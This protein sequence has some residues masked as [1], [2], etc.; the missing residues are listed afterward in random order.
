MALCS[1]SSKLTT[2]GYT[3]I[4]NNFFNEFLPQATGDDVKVYL[5]G[6]TLCNTLSSDENSLDTICKVLSLTEEQVLK[7][8]D[9]WQMVGLVQVVSKNPY[10]VRY[11]P[12]RA[13]SGSVKIRNKEKYADFNEQIQTVI[14]G[15]MITPTEFNEYYSLIE[16]YHFEP[17]AVVL[18]ASYCTK[19]KNTSIG[20]PYIMAVA[21]DFEKQ[22]LKT[23]SAIENKLIEKE[24]STAEIKQ[25]LSALGL[26]READ[27]EERNLYLK[28]TNNFGFIH[29]VIVEV[30][31]TLKK[32]G[33]FIK[34]D[35][36][37]SKYYEQKLFT[38]EE[39]LS[40]SENRDSMFELAKTV[41]KT[42]GLYYQN[43][44][45]IVDTYIA[46]W[47]NKGYDN[48]TL[49]FIGHYCFKQS[50]RTLEGMNTIIQKFF[51]LGLISLA[52]IE[53]YISGI[54]KT[55]E[56]IKEVVDKTGLIRQ[57]S[58]LDREFYKTWTNSWGFTHEQILLAAE[59]AKDKSNP[60]T[61]LNKV[62]AN[63]NEQGV[64]D[65][66]A[67]KEKLKE[68]KPDA[69]KTSSKQTK[70][71]SFEKHNYS[72]EQLDAVFTSLDDVEI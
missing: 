3:V 60:M 28:W 26:K 1:Y 41:S 8:F 7:A 11:L 44:E 14:S 22:G 65:T 16:V 19:M 46:D 30:A 37:L 68:I 51:K 70:Q 25:V 59:T 49:V 64:N 24:K 31:K 23:F 50:I 27:I 56:L 48:D 43:F 58:S 17:E 53:Q 32:R 72:R 4:D 18:L 69:R 13:H 35:E 55:D 71:E 63:L 6:L 57:I 45:N 20:Y 29:G 12:V 15:R 40:F 67:I 9:Y 21:R 52:S 62:I 33:G 36:L 38:M 5:Y 66:K 10:E 61:Y 54:L 2:E 47:T 34:L 39:V 42:L